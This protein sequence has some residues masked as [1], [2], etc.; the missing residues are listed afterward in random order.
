VE[1]LNDSRDAENP[2]LAEKFIIILKIRHRLTLMNTDIKL[3]NV[4]RD[5]SYFI[6]TR[7]RDIN[8]T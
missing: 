8:E 7:E 1:N 2:P 5:L 4:A 3:E 6:K